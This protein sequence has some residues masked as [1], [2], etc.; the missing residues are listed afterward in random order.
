CTGGSAVLLPLHCWADSQG[1][2]ECVERLGI[3]FLYL[4]PP[5]VNHMDK[6]GSPPP[7][8]LPLQARLGG[9]GAAR[10]VADLQ[11]GFLPGYAG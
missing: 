11:G 2:W 6:E 10:L 5:V 4:V 9:A 7:A 1:F 8:R 3:S